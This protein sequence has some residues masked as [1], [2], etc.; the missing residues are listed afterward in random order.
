[1][2]WINRLMFRLKYLT[3]SYLCLLMLKKGTPVLTYGRVFR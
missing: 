2:G 1:M 3:L